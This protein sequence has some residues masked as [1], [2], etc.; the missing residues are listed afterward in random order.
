MSSKGLSLGCLACAIETP[1][2]SIANR[3][4]EGAGHRDAMRGTSK[5]PGS[6]APVGRKQER[7]SAE[8]RQGAEILAVAPRRRSRNGWRPT[9]RKVTLADLR[10]SRLACA[11]G[12][13]VARTPLY[14]ADA[15][16]NG[17]ALE[18]KSS[19]TQTGR[20][21]SGSCALFGVVQTQ[22]APLGGCRDRPSELRM[23]GAVE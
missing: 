13:P 8:R 2:P 21:K 11:G 4:R 10:P 22:R 18:K 12:E 14:R 23:N 19:P 5:A 7:S 1:D 15:H 6:S 20:T 3:P 9:R 16:L 17:K